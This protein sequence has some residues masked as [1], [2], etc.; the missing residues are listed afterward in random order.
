MNS[1]NVLYTD[2]I[3]EMNNYLITRGFKPKG[4]TVFNKESSFG[5]WSI[6]ICAE[7]KKDTSFTLS[8]KIGY[9]INEIEM[10]NSGSNDEV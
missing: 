7:S 8:Y 5:N 1:Q 4:K 6:K 10:Q 9:R 3:W 2:I